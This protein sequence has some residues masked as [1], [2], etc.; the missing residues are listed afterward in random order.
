MCECYQV[1]GPWIEADPDCPIHGRGG[2]W[3]H[4]REEEQRDADME[5]RIL[6]LEEKIKDLESS[7]ETRILELEQQIF[8]LQKANQKILKAITQLNRTGKE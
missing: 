2:L 8:V 4:Q 3:E 1:G 6:T 5:T 7:H